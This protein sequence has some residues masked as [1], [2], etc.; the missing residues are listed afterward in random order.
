MNLKW[1][2]NQE[3]INQNFLN[4]EISDKIPVKGVLIKNQIFGKEW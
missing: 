2:F 4:Q 1:F 3:P